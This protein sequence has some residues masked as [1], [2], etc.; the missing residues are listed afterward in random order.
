MSPFFIVLLIWIGLC[1]V[2]NI[3]MLIRFIIGFGC[4][5]IKQGFGYYLCF[6]CYII[7][8]CFDWIHCLLIG[9]NEYSFTNDKNNYIISLIICIG[10]IFYFIGSL[11][12]YL[13]LLIRLYLI[14]ANKK[15]KVKPSFIGLMV[16][17]IL[18][19]L[20][21]M[22]IYLFPINKPIY[23][24]KIPVILI[25][26][27]ELI[28]S[29]ILSVS[30]VK[31][32]RWYIVN[33]IKNINS[34]DDRELLLNDMNNNKNAPINKIFELTIKHTILSIIM[35]FVNIWFYSILLYEI[36]IQYNDIT[37]TIE[38]TLRSFEMIS[39]GI[40]LSLSLKHNNKAYYLLCKCCHN[41]CIK[42]SSKKIKKMTCTRDS[43]EN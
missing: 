37:A 4:K 3:C 33:Q 14:F 23:Q 20:V 43:L 19:S 18:F 1:V 21:M 22:G 35:V 42:Y 36:L 9:Y 34:I 27:N 6:I 10:D 30:F 39:L 12:L 11:S 5:H 28:I 24:R 29:V 32:L 17:L 15:Y 2:L 38:Y 7:T 16:L 13:L 8:G 26:V 40:L 31:K 41:R 25:C